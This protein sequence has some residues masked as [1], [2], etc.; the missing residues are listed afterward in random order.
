[1]EQIR[2]HKYYIIKRGINGKLLDVIGADKQ[3]EVHRIIR[4]HISLGYQLTIVSRTVMVTAD[5]LFE[6]RTFIGF[7]QFS[8]ERIKKD[9]KA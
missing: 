5:N 9:A 6:A 4:E 7:P 2:D 1:M 3:T 8:Q